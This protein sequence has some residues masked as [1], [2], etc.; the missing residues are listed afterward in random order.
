MY[1]FQ[2]EDAAAN[3]FRFASGGG[4]EL[5]FVDEKEVDI[6]DVVGASI[7]KVPA[8]TSIRSHWLAIEGVQPAIPENP[9]PLSIDSPRNESIDPASNPGG[10]GG[11]A[12]ATG[13]YAPTVGKPI[14]FR[15]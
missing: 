15:S 4:R 6:A 12:S 13:L 9:P 3:L 2:A 10:K 5:H 1:G 8:E 11:K 14:R 7:P